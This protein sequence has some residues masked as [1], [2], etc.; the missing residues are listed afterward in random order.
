MIEDGYDFGCFTSAKFSYPEFDQ[1]IFAKLPANVLH[2]D[3]DGVTYQRDIRNTKRLIDFIAA[4]MRDEAGDP[5]SV[6]PH[7][8]MPFTM[9]LPC[10]APRFSVIRRE[11]A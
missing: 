8:M 2:S 7:P 10:R 3:D 4:G 9:P 11:R 6:V 1:T 5:L